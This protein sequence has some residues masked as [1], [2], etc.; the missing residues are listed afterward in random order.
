M[1]QA[2]LARL[3]EVADHVVLDRDVLGALGDRR[4][5][6]HVDGRLV[7]LIHRRRGQAVKCRVGVAEELPHIAVEVA[8]LETGLDALVQRLVLRLRRRVGHALQLATL[9][10]ERRVERAKTVLSRTGYESLDCAIPYWL[11]EPG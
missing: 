3:G 8:C 10:E 4:G 2:D 9:G 11:R 5:G 6:H 1:C 7:V